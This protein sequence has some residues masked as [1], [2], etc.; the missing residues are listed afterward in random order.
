MSRHEHDG[1]PK[2][3]W[4]TLDDVE[5]VDVRQRDVEKYEIRRER[6]D[7]RYRVSPGAALTDDGQVV[8]LAENRAQPGAG[9]GLVVHYQHADVRHA[10]SSAEPS[11]GVVCAST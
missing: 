5:P 7:G 2:L 6:L 10:A 8:L 1:R 9:E 3:A 11:V 4:H